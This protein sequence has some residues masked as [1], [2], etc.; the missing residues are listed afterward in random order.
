MVTTKIVKHNGKTYKFQRVT[1]EP[2]F[3]DGMYIFPLVGTIYKNGPV[4][5][6][7]QGD[8][9][10]EKLLAAGGELIDG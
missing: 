9:G 3:E 2:H 1:A 6:L 8:A 5:T 4:Y 7:E 10:L